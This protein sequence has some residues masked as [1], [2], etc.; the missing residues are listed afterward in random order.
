MKIVEYL[1]QN[2]EPYPE[3]LQQPNLNFNRENFLSTRTVYYPGSG[4][5]GHPVRLCSR[6]HAA[7][8]FIYVDYDVSIKE[9]HDSVNGVGDHHGFRGYSV[10]H[11]EEVE[12]SF[13]RPDGWVRHVSYPVT[14][15]NNSFF[16]VQPFALYFV[17]KRVDDLD[18]EHGPERFAL[19]AV[20]DD[21]FVTYDAIFC[22][23][24]G[25]TPPFLVLV[26]DYAFGGGNYNRFGSEGLLEE[27][28]CITDVFPNYLLADDRGRNV[29]T[30]YEN[31]GARPSKGGMHNVPRSL[32]I[33]NKVENNI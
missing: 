3:W 26:E 21:G 18:A 13:L 15:H 1:K 20:G 2:P 9:I 28:A 30:G 11:E 8:A 12:M 7:H 22:Q 4:N 33:R 19:L 5:D 17:L 29:W 32:F 27:I 24:D 14:M 31:T 10:E 16:S 23:N 6:S 25:A